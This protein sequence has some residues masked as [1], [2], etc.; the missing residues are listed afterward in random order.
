MDII[1]FENIVFE[2]TLPV[3][4]E[5]N[6]LVWVSVIQAN[7]RTDFEDGLRT[8]TKLG[9]RDGLQSIHTLN[10]RI[11]LVILGLAMINPDGGVDKIPVQNPAMF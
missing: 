9:L 2:K 1:F 4:I 3:N 6:W 7:G 11:W 8:G 10:Q 5:D